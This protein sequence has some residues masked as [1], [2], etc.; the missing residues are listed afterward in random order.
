M[1]NDARLHVPQR[2]SVGGLIALLGL[3]TALFCM[4]S[5]AARQ[6]GFADFAGSWFGSGYVQSASGSE[7]IRCRAQ[8]AVGPDGASVEQRLVCASA[9]YKFNIDCQATES[10]GAIS[11]TWTETTRSVTGTLSGSLRGGQLQA[12]V[13]SPFFTAG[14]SFSTS[15]NR[16]DVVISP[17]G[18]DIRQ[19]VVQLRRR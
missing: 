4:P 14:L 7:A 5:Y 18:N 13:S 17:Q 2:R 1:R 6:G 10:N 12:Q 11:G 3:A 9:S 19:V 8:Y 15:R 16:Q